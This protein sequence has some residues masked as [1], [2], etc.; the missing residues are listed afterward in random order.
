[1][2][3][4]R[5]SRATNKQKKCYNHHRNKFHGNIILE[6]GLS[7][8]KKYDL[9]VIG[10]GASGMIASI[11]SARDSKKVLLLE[12]L[13]QIGAK[14]KASGGGRCNLTNT[15]SQDEFMSHFGRD[16]RF[17]QDALKSFSNKE[18]I[19]FFKTI[20]V[21]TDAL[22]GFRVFPTSHNSSTII[23]AL[24]DEMQRLGVEVK[25][26]QK[27]KKLLE[28]N[29]EIIGVK[30]QTDT[31][32]APNV[33]LS[34]GGLGYP[35]LGSEGDGYTMAEELGHKTTKLYPA[36]MP[37]KTK[38]SWVQNC[39][40]DTIPKA[41]IRIDIKK[42]KKLKASG[43]LIFTKNGIR[44]PVV[45][46]F[47]REITPL[48]DNYDEIPLLVN[49]TKGLNEEQILLHL[50]QKAL[51]EPDADMVTLLSTL[52]PASISKELLLLCD[53]DAGTTFKK[54]NGKAKAKLINYLSWTPLTITGHDGFKMAMVTRGGINL[55]EI[56]P[57]TMQSKL[58]K[59]LYFC[60]EIVNLDGPCGGYNLQWAFSSGYL[61][62]KSIT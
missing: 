12:K 37:L 45:L 2:Q 6:N 25:T 22:D 29:S 42:H 28:E 4:Q 32:Y 50:Q 56:E 3:S 44:G 9:I 10:A 49:M 41:T 17:M 5:A 48:F 34:T 58:V 14:L 52:L 31:F 21:D 61:A 36:M 23:S 53:V 33:I 51:K 38:E 8:L 15:L 24:K 26:S 16:G 59:G 46:D 11:T 19:D 40:A 18:L 47:A 60:G 27:V 43:D 39:R 13:P 62:G 30:T 35:T 20:G 1:M 57:K 54:V 55:K 7:L